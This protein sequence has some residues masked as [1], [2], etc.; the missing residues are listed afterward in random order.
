MSAAAAK[1]T[2]W[3]RDEH[4]PGERRTLV[5]PDAARALAEAG[6]PLVLERSAGRAFALE[7]YADAAPHI[8]AGGAWRDAPRDAIVLG[9]KELDPALG[10]FAHRHA[11]FAHAFKYQRGW[12]DTVDAFAAGG[13]TLFDLEYLVDADGR[14]VAAFGRDAGFVGAALALLA[15]AGR[16]P[17]PLVAWADRAALVRDVREALADAP[18][19]A[20]RV[21]VIGARGRS[22]RGAVELCEAVGARATAWD[23]DETAGGGPF[24][25]AL[26]HD[27]LVSCVYVEAPVAPFVTLESLRAGPAA[28]VRRLRAIVDVGCDPFGDGNPL[29]LYAAPTTLDAPSLRL[30]EPDGAPGGAPAVDLVAIDHLPALLPREA[31]GDFAGQLLPHL[32]GLDRPDRGVWARARAVFD[33]RLAE[34]AQLAEA[35][36]SAGPGGGAS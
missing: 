24:D 1:P 21:L 27:A 17:E 33:A 5:P 34:A 28:G 11:H 20:P 14:R 22:G 16:L 19:A 29:P 31:S 10:P 23:V 2:L 15:L 36:R 35:A 26:G 7:E 30:V 32:L 13:G 3:L 4:K 9:L 6:Y 12:R 18:D 8:V 25:A